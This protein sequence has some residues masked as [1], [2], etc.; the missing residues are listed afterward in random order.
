MHVVCSCVYA[1]KITVAFTLLSAV[2]ACVLGP[3]TQVPHAQEAGA[4]AAALLDVG[5]WQEEWLM[6]AG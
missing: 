3:H 1:I 2:Y 4:V 6:G 5:G